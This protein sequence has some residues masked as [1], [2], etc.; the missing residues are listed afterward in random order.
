[1]PTKPLTNREDPPEADLQTRGRERP[2]AA[3]LRPEADEPDARDTDFIPHWH[4]PPTDWRKEHDIIV[5]AQ[6]RGLTAPRAPTTDNP[7][8]LRLRLPGDG[9]AATPVPS[10]TTHHDRAWTRRP[11]LFAPNASGDTWKVLLQNTSRQLGAL[12]EVDGRLGI[13]RRDH[14]STLLSFVPSHHGRR[15]L[16][17]PLLAL[18]LGAAAIVFSA[19]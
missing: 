11:Y 5:G 17:P 9:L 1:M 6:L 15:L 2:A 16:E 10:G 4:R 3:F 13:R 14:W 8:A 19:R 12:A 18:S 7:C